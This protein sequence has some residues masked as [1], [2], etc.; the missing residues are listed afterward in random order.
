MY[1]DA[2]RPEPSAFRE[3]LER[4]DIQ[5][6]YGREPHASERIREDRVAP[7]ETVH[8]REEVRDLDRPIGF[9]I[10][11]GFFGW[12][13]ASFFTLLFVGLTLA[14]LGAQAYNEAS[15]GDGAVDLARPDWTTL[16]TA[17]AVAGLVSILVAYFLGGYAAGRIGLRSGAL[18]GVMVV[19]WTVLATLLAAVLAGAAAD[20]FDLGAYV[21][22]FAI[23][24]SAVTTET[25]IG[26][27]IVLLTML[28]GAILGGMLGDRWWAA[29]EDRAAYVDRRYRSRTRPRV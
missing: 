12:A 11:A 16:S 18:H 17:G 13:V 26:L 8:E 5:G 14:A 28:V 1:Y 19:V 15:T 4:N 21:A 22:P 20:A 3:A 27:G 7:S 23:D 25:A 6:E 9:S 2:D 24:W 10:A 29:D